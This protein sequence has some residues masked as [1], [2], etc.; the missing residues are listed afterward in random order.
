V[1]AVLGDLTKD[2]DALHMSDEAYVEDK[3]QPVV[4]MLGIYSD[5]YLLQI[6]PS[7]YKQPKTKDR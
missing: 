2:Y 4:L 1:R 5:A 7:N 6:H 3:L